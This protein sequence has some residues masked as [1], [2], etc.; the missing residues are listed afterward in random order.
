MYSPM[1]QQN[2]S[3][4]WV[5]SLFS[6]LLLSS[7]TTTASSSNN[8]NYYYVPMGWQ[9][10]PDLEGSTFASQTIY[11]A[12][13]NAVVITGSTFGQFFA[14]QPDEF[15]RTSS[16]C[17]LATVQLPSIT[18]NKNINM[19]W[20]NKQTFGDTEI[21]EACSN[22]AYMQRGEK[23]IIS[24]YSEIGGFVD[25]KYNPSALEESVQYGFLLD[26]NVNNNNNQAAFQLNGARVLQASKVMY[27]VAMFV[28]N[29]AIYVA[30]Q[31]TNNVIVNE[32]NMNGDEFQIDDEVDPMRFFKYGENYRMSVARY[33]LIETQPTSPG[34]PLQDSFIQ[35]WVEKL[36]TTDSK[37]I[38]VAG[39]AE[40]G[41]VVVVV[42]TTDGQGTSFGS[43]PII[44]V[45]TLDGFITKL[46]VGTGNL[47]EEQQGKSTARRIQSINA[48]D[49]WV[50]GMCHDPND[51]S[52]FYILGATTGQLDEQAPGSTLNFSVQAFIMKVE[53][54]T[55]ETIWTQQFSA[56][57]Q[58]S[59]ETEVR[60]ISCVVSSDSQSVWFG[61]VVQSGA[62]LPNSGTTESFGNDDIFVAKLYAEDGQPHFIRQI[63]SSE[64][65]G[66][67]MRGSL[68]LDSQGNCVVVGNTYGS[69]Y[70]TRDLSQETHWISDVF[71]TT[72]TNDV[73]AI[74]FPVEHSEFKPESLTNAGTQTN[75]DDPEDDVAVKAPEQPAS[76]SGSAKK[77]MVIAVIVSLI[78]G[79]L[80]GMACF[81]KKLA[82][83]NRDVDTDRSKVIEYLSDFDV[84]DIDMKRS[85]TGGWHIC[86]SNDLAIGLNRR[87]GQE[88]RSSASRGS[89]PLLTMPLTNSSVLEDSLFMDDE[90][91]SENGS[92]GLG[93]GNRF[94]YS[95]YSRRQGYDGLVDS[96]KSTWEERRADDERCAW[97]K[98]IL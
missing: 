82:A 24:G 5:L 89:D 7:T 75:E 46:N 44:Q 42:G 98:E 83:L 79:A 43:D 60:G 85:A 77:G 87:S 11:D 97:G 33:R 50:A 94:S 80:F 20:I 48:R 39:V 56:D 41:D 68:T 35:G 32:E 13:Q 73:G 92:V 3:G 26:V 27:S 55:L 74:A 63:G 76:Q 62:V 29:E 17:F 61:G 8:N 10:G 6:L 53:T 15:P 49:D 90:D 71:V 69:M 84:D 4:W 65:D 91:A 31:E 9:S 51:L 64:D 59:D 18:S 23:L 57:R 34:S 28:T 70:R 14:E 66:L 36:A 86:Y 21:M 93:D 1:K 19:T 88:S 58:P 52:Y 47:M 37:S 25:S 78:A 67:A 54:A 30:S 12:K 38:H 45:G 95:N 96:Y 40:L 16:S 72:I 2:L 81:A 22:L